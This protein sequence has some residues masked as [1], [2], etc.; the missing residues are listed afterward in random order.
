MCMCLCLCVSVSLSVS[1]YVYGVCFRVTST[2]PHCSGRT[3]VHGKPTQR[4]QRIA[5]TLADLNA[6]GLNAQT[7]NDLLSMC[8]GAA[9]QHVLRMS[10][11][12]EREAQNF[13]TQV[14]AFW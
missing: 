5:T 4:F 13:D 12:P 6:E 9:S 8:V 3:G 7:A 1:V 2:Q 14:T 11:V 10:F